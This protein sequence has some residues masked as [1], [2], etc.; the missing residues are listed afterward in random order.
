MSSALP[1][2]TASNHPARQRMLDVLRDEITRADCVDIAVSFLRFSGLS[3]IIECLQAFRARGGRLRLLTSTYLGVTQ[4]DA[5]RFLAESLNQEELRVYD[6]SAPGFHIKLFVFG[7]GHSNSC[8]VGSSNLT[9]GGL[10]SNLELNVNNREPHVVDA[11]HKEFELLWDDPASRWPDPAFV[12]EYAIR[13]RPKLTLVSAAKVHSDL[14]VAEPDSAYFPVATTIQAPIIAPN[15]AQREALERL[16]ELRLRGERR[17]VVIAAPGVGKTF[18]SAFDAAQAGAKTILFVSHRLEHLRQ[19]MSTFERVFPGRPATLLDSSSNYVAHAAMVFASIQSLTRSDLASYLWDYIVIDE[20]HHAHA[21]TYRAVIANSRG[22]FLLGLTATPERQDGHDVLALCDYNVAWEVR[23]HDAIRRRWL[24]PFHYFAVADDTVDYGSIPWRNGRFEPTAV[25][26]ALIIERRVDLAVQQ[27][28]EKGFDGARR[29]T[30]GF[31][32]GRRHAEF[33]A[34][35]FN[36]RGLTS[37]FV[38][39]EHAIAERERIYARFADSNDPLEWLFVADVLNEGVDIPAINSILFLRPTDS[40]TI[41]IQQLGRGLRLH[42]DCEVLTVVDLVGH[43]RRSWLSLQALNDPQALPGLTTVSGLPV[44]LTPPPGCEIVL[45]ERTRAI[46]NKVER[47]TSSR[48]ERCKDAWELM[49]SDIGRSPYP[50]DFIGRDEDILPEDFRATFGDWISARVH[51]GDAEPWERSLADD[52]PLRGLLARCE[53]NWQ[54]QRVY[55]YALL[56]GHIQDAAEPGRGFAQFFDRFPR[57]RVE[58]GDLGEATGYTTLVKKLGSLWHEGGLDSRVFD[59]IDRGQLLLEVERRIQ[60]HLEK[61]FRM[62][63][64][65]V[66]RT[67]SDL[68]LWNRY[69]RPNIINH[70]GLQFDPARHNTGVLTFRDSPFDDH[71]IVITKLDTSTAQQQFHYTN[72]FEDSQTLRWQSQNRNTPSTE[73]GR[74]LVTPGAAKIHLFVQE[75]SHASAVYC[76][77]VTPIRYERSGPIDVWFRLGNPLPEAIAHAL[78]GMT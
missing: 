45:D 52:A 57:W 12:A 23:L 60:Y 50:I 10:A 13:S 72:A 70:F 51:M 38:T 65:G 31:C 62:R 20:F 34:N 35:R 26:N 63:H 24:I 58:A 14:A 69:R 18:L 56:W 28:I 11:I 32:A 75:R 68:K 55:P 6:S 64:G 5:L 67:P 2:P 16:R 76:G 29:A 33:M 48:R 53:S 66:L 7:H 15:E 74:R 30:V 54:A 43:H 78:Y 25:E 22:A 77:L 46:L 44:E 9:K 8:W 41:F 39:G 61:D 37:S 36:A 40:A 49:R 4:A 47:F 1:L 71:I 59:V 19:A 17:A 3:L 73:P 42:P 27:A 21:P